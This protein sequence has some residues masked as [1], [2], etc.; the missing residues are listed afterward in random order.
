M[1]LEIIQKNYEIS[2]KLHE[3]IEKKVGKLEKYFDKEANCKVV[4]KEDNKKFKLEITISGKGSFF[5]S[6]VSGDNMY[7]NLDLALP[8]IEKQI[9]KYSGKRNDAFK[10]PTLSELLFT[11]VLPE[12]VYA[13][14][15]TKRKSFALDPITEEDAI[16]M[17]EATDHDFYVF[18]N[19]ETGL[20]SVLYRK[21]NEQYG[22]IEVKK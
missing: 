21:G 9:V 12:E 17:L 5:R 18:L 11:S 1:K 6:E 10:A 15:I 2:K 14:K 16:Y 8:K 3:L 19:A 22:I 13:P 7:E 20:V 4:C